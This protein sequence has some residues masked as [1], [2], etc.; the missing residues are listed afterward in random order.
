MG[1]ESSNLLHLHEFPTGGAEAEGLVN[2]RG[3]DKRLVIPESN[4]MGHRSV[5]LREKVLKLVDL[6]EIRNGFVTTEFRPSIAFPTF[7]ANLRPPHRLHQPRRT[8]AINTHHQI[9]NQQPNYH[10]NSSSG[11]HC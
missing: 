9:H 7:G 8:I 2:S 5:A 1:E 3:D 11:P 6:E 10:R 4:G